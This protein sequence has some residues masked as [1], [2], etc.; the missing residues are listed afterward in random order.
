VEINIR[1]NKLLSENGVCSRR[2]ADRLLMEKRVTWEGKPVE[3]GARV[4]FSALICVDGKPILREKEKVIL[5]FNKPR[6]IECTANKEVDNNVIS[7]LQ[8]D[9]RL[10][11]AGRLDKDSEGLLIMTNDGD[12]IN[13]MMRA[14]NVHEKEYLVTINQP[15][16]DAFIYA[17][18]NGVEILDTI[19][20]P[21]TVKKVSANEFTIILTQGLNRQIRRMC[22]ALSVKVER[23]KRIRVMNIVLGDLKTGDY[24]ELTKEE[25][26]VL[27]DS[28]KNSYNAYE[29]IS[30]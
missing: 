10:L 20:R 7:F 30:K 2:E 24:R 15:I 19:T 5:A 13:R 21:C 9:K 14:G 1:I 29:E 22:E 12:I 18:E 8:Y 17:M 27:R 11:Y 23:L 4:P 16:T 26:K 28:I 3:L 6:G 25:E